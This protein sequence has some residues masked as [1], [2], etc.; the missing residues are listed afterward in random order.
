MISE[1]FPE[2]GTAWPGLEENPNPKEEEPLS[3]KWL[4]NRIMVHLVTAQVHEEEK[5]FPN[6]V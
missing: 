3:E 1:A 5:A 2:I 6:S 4:F